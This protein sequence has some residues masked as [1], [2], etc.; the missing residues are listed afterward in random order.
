MERASKAQNRH[1]P[2]HP[3]FTHFPIALWV[4][5]W[6][7]DF[8]S[9][10]V[11]NPMVRS[12]FYMHAA[13]VAFALLAAVAGMLDY[14]KI[15][16]RDPAKRLGVIHALLN[17]AVVVLFAVVTWLRLGFLNAERAPAICVVLTGV[18]VFFLSAAGYLGHKLVFDH[19][20]NVVRMA[21]DRETEKER[22]IDFSLQPRRPVHP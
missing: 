16:A 18:G 6:L 13:G 17:V 12:S 11:G 3:P 2:L 20:A 22:Q 5:A 14:N 8:A 15:P 19:G 7:F 10:W 4:T 9:L 21:P 1:T